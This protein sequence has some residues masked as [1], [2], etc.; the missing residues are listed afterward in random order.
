MQ[1]INKMPVTLKDIAKVCNVSYSTVSRALNGKKVRPS[2]KLD[3]IRE[4]A[5]A[6]GYKPNTLAVQLVT[7]KTNKIGLL[8]PDIA[9]PHYSEIA[10]SVEDAAFDNGYQIFLCNSDWS[11]RKEVLYRDAL[12]DSRVAGIITMPVCDE[13][14]VLFHGLDTPVVLLG[15]RTKE[16]DLSTVVMDNF[17]AAYRITE[18][19]IR[20][21]H[22]RLAYIGRK[23]KNY[24]S[25]DREA[26][27]FAAVR[28]NADAVSSAEAVVSTSFQLVGG[29]RAAME[30][31]QRD[32]K[33][34]GIIA[35][36]DFIALGAIQ[37]VEEYG[38]KPGVDIEI[39]GFDDIQFSSL[40]KINLT[41]ITPSNAELGRLAINTIIQASESKEKICRNILLEPHIIYRSTYQHEKDKPNGSVE[42]R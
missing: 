15:S 4:T 5:R 11:V 23:V 28:D 9:N 21:G 10:K 39:I 31:L 20:S 29:Y 41:T 12:L 40:P 13:S 8:V 17:K 6:L 16:N 37:A 19:L 32:E 25:S 38:L 22:D 1:R 18:E 33:T 3:E 14:H 35:F 42:V 36:N 7:R 24:T 27:F 34:N 26:G 30:L 2:R